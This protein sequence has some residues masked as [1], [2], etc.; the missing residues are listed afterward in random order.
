[1]CRLYDDS[2]L[3]YSGESGAGKTISAKYIMGYLSE[4]ASGGTKKIEV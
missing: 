3:L 2:F 4:V 1:M